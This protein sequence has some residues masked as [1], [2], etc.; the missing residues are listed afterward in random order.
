MG[1]LSNQIK[2]ISQLSER[3][4]LSTVTETIDAYGAPKFE[5][6]TPTADIP[7]MVRYEDTREVVNGTDQEKF[8]QEI[9]VWIRYNT[10]ATEFKQLLWR[11]EYYD[12]YAIERVDGDRYQVFKARLIET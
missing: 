9:K 4:G 7:A 1:R 5:R 12:I 11:S 3:I 10:N 6:T 8:I 2:S